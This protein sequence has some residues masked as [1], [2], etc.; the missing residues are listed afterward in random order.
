MVNTF[1]PF[2]DYSEV[3]RALDNK[4]LGKQRVETLQILKANL[5]LTKGWVNHPAAVMWR[6]CE[7]ELVIYGLTVIKEWRSRG[8]VDLLVEV[9]MRELMKSLPGCTFKEP[10][11]LK[12]SEFHQSHQSNLKRKD[13]LHYDF[14]VPDDLPYLWPMPDGTMRIT[15]K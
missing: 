4:R 2:P 15:K 12:N 6:G 7:G 8:F 3:A 5:G 1:L 13:P 14:D 10:W 9:Q 11:W